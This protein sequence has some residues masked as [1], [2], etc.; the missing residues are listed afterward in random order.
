MNCHFNTLI[1]PIL[2]VAAATAP[3]A[4][5]NANWSG[6][7]DFYRHFASNLNHKNFVMAAQAAQAA[8]VQAAQ[9]AGDQGV[10]QSSP[11]S[12]FPNMS[13]M[14]QANNTPAEVTELSA[15]QKPIAS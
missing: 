6:N 13:P 4:N 11:F 15:Q 7:L 1:Q 10:S 5:G 8:A 9:Q 3:A 14:M 2:S 12:F